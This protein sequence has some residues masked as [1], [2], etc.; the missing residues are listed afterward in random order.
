M[1]D[2]PDPPRAPSHLGASSR[3]LWNLMVL[4]FDLDP[5]SLDVLR[6]ALEARDVAATARRRVARDGIVLDGR[7]GPVAHP[8]VNIEKQAAERYARLL[9][10]L[11]LTLPED[12]PRPD[13][14][15]L[16]KPGGRNL[17]ASAR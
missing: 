12:E 14:R 10:D 4:E 16:L 13:G 7:F 3:R 5:A 6:V 2:H 17:K 9:R 11:G 15:S 1:T 8:A